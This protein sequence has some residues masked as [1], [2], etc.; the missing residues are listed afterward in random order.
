[1]KA[2]TTL[3]GMP[4]DPLFRVWFLF[5]LWSLI[6]CFFAWDERWPS[7]VWLF[8]AGLTCWLLYRR[9]TFAGIVGFLV[10]GSAVAVM[11]SKGWSMWSFLFPSYPWTI[12]PLPF[13]PYRAVT[14]LYYLTMTLV[15]IIVLMEHIASRHRILRQFEESV[16]EH[17]HDGRVI[18]PSGYYLITRR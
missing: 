14:G 9:S 11:L 12:P 10:S 17:R 13:L 7:F 6:G 2:T 16:A 5:Y 8:G 15:P 4:R 3:G 18:P 1:M